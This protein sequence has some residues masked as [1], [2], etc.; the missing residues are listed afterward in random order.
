MSMRE[1]AQ[2]IVAGGRG[3]LAA[4]ESTPT[5]KKRFDT[6]NLESTETSRRDYRELLFRTPGIE[7]YI[8]GVILYDETLRQSAKDGTTFIKLLKG[9]DIAP[10]IKVDMGAKELSGA[11]N[12]KV[13]EGLDG[14]RGRLKEYNELGAVFAKW[15]AVIQIDQNITPTYQCLKANAEGLAR[16]A[17]I[18][19][20]AGIVPIVE[21]EVIMDGSHSIERCFEVTS[22]ALQEVFN[23]LFVHNVDLES[24]L[25]KPN[26][27]ISG[28]KNSTQAPVDEV[29]DMTIRCLKNHVPS[30]V[31]GIVFLSGGQSD[32]KA[33]EHLNSMNARHEMP[34]KVSYSYG[35][36]L[37]APTIKA[38]GGKEANVA[39]AQAQL[40]HRAKCNSLAAQGQYLSSVEGEVS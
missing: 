15:R 3:I 38:W 40:I 26:M 19:Q 34:W 36:A 16:Y 22:H 33:T 30:S 5:I 32:I 21:P 39:A 20:E 2:K 31:P 28:T 9:L 25:L 24:I 14:L 23:S 29:A 18:C 12:E 11:S 10:G 35:R 4:D 13:T 7:K 8:S 1:V 17:S 27:V 6:I 37:Q